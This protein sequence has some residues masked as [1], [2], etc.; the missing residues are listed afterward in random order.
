MVVGPA[1]IFEAFSALRA[2][3]KIDLEGA[4]GPLNFDLA[5]GEVAVDQAILCFGSGESAEMR[6][7][8]LIYDPRTKSLRGKLDCP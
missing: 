1:G 3:K 2:G 8:G 4:F 6:E 5:T 7:S